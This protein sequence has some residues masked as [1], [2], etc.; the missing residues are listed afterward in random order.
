MRKL[1]LISR[2]MGLMLL[3]LSIFSCGNNSAK[4]SQGVQIR[5]R[6]GM[7]RH[8]ERYG[9]RDKEVLAVMKSVPRH[10][11]IPEMYR[12]TYDAYGDHPGPIGYG[13]TISQPYIVAYMTEK[14]NL[15]PGEK[16]LEVGT[17]S[18]YQAAVLAGLEARVYTIEIVPELAAHAKKILAD[19]EYGQ[20]RV[21]AGDGYKG[22]PEYAPFDAIIVTCAPEKI[23]GALV[24]QLKEGGRM[25][26]PLGARFQQ[27]L[28]I[29]RKKVG[30][31]IVEEDLPVRFVPMVHGETT[32]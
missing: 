10:L 13:Q 22:W 1:R 7:V 3:A 20:V 16:V 21:L 8:L 30:K 24:E 15:K 6:A 17:G 4:L 5:A 25:I 32:E 27:R 12:D 26:L 18:G 19:E 2:R 14:L 28:V 31:V 23:P 11:F 29:C 9:I